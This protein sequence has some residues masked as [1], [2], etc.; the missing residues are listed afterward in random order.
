LSLRCSY[1]S[2]GTSLHSSSS[3]SEGTGEHEYFLIEVEDTGRGIPEDKLG[4]VFVPF[5]QIHHEQKKAEGSGLGLSLAKK[6]TEK[7][8][9]TLEV[10]SKVGKGST[11]YLKIPLKVLPRGT[12]C[13][14][15]EDLFSASGLGTSQI[16]EDMKAELIR[17]KNQLS[18]VIMT[19][20]EE[21][22]FCRILS[23]YL[24]YWGIPYRI[25]TSFPERGKKEKEWR[26]EKEEGKEAVRYLIEDDPEKLFALLSVLDASEQVPEKPDSPS[27]SRQAA[28]LKT[29]GNLGTSFKNILNVT[30]IELRDEGTQEEVIFLSTFQQISSM[31]KEIKVEENQKR[32]HFL[33]KTGNPS[34]LFRVILLALGIIFEQKGHSFERTLSFSL[35]EDQQGTEEASTKDPLEEEEQQEQEEKEG[36]EKP[37][38]KRE[39]EETPEDEEERI[40]VLVVE[41]NEVSQMIMKKILEKCGV[42]YQMT[43]SGEEAVRIW[44]E[45]KKKIPLIL[46]D[47]EV[48]GDMTGLEATAEIRKEEERRKKNMKGKKAEKYKSFVVIMTGRSMDKDMKEAK[49]SG[50]DLFLTKPVKMQVLQKLIGEVLLSK[51]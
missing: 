45:R 3:L 40:D 26:R 46:M 10:Q 8:G 41:D 16:P 1:P 39:E 34:E 7:L 49:E 31:K 38:E 17:R 14:P 21:S 25:T 44:K 32:I 47:V 28:S 33:R 5:T 35:E 18:V 4:D 50:C 37:T 23:S 22:H 48:D 12:L 20:S 13:F 29:E 6:I 24:T 36:A 15:M 2:D 30:E 51:R 43:S 42:K 11:F 27:D 19:S 9:G